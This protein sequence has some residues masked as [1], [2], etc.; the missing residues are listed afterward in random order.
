[1][2]TNYVKETLQPFVEMQR[3]TTFL[4]AYRATTSDA[5]VLGI[6]LSKYL[7]WD[8]IAILEAAVSALEDANFHSEAKVVA[9]LLE[10]N[11]RT[12]APTSV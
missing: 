3:N 9:G 2:Q 12:F 10:A 4:P 8:G 6:I 5:R 11:K 7:E 1:M